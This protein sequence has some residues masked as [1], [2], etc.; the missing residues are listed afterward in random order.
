MFLCDSLF[1]DSEDT[2]RFAELTG[3]RPVIE[4]Y[5]PEKAVQ[6]YARLTRE[7]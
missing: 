4:T 3:G 1:A 6:A 7:G 2:L 5:P